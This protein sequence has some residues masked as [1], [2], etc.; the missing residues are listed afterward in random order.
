MRIYFPMSCRI[1][2]AGHIKCLESLNKLGLV[3]IG[4]LTSKALKGYKKDIV[5]Y[6]DREYILETVAMALGNIEIVPQ[7]SR[8]P[9][10]NVKKYRCKALAS[11]DGFNKWE[12]GAIKKLKL[13]KINIKLKGEKKK[14]YSSS[15]ILQCGKE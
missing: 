9:S 4:L 12:A 13:N 1:L 10:I 11:G 2:T 5:P 3:Y 15:K 7:D 8:D 6:K 14:L